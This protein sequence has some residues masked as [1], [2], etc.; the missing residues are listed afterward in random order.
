MRRC[1]A[2]R[3]S[4]NP[5]GP[6]VRR[7]LAVVRQIGA[8][9]GALARVRMAQAVSTAALR[10]WCH[11]GR[12]AAGSRVERSAPLRCDSGPLANGLAPGRNA[13]W[14]FGD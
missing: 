4:A 11:V 13:G 9:E 12:R 6:T 14:A 1:C 3:A 8:L 2:R 10:A 7:Q 5:A